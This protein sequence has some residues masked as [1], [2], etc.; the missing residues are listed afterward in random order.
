MFA[1]GEKEKGD[2]VRLGVGFQ[3]LNTDFEMP[4]DFKKVKKL[5]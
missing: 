2:S 3:N 1:T 5:G 4:A